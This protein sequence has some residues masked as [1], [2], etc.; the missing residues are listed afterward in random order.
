MNNIAIIPCRRNS[1]EVKNK[2]IKIFNKKPLL[3]WTIKSARSSSLI[4]KV[5]VTSD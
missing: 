3:Y 4:S 2:N 5:F 1:K